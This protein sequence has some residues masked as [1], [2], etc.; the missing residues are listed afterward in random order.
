MKK[1]DKLELAFSLAVPATVLLVTGLMGYY[2]VVF[3]DSV[4]KY[5]S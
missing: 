2:T 1:I 5:I 3:A 4:I